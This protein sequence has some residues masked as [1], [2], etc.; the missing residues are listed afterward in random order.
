MLPNAT[1]RRNLIVATIMLGVMLVI[2]GPLTVRADEMTMSPHRIILNAQG[3][4]ENVQAVIRIPLKSGYVL[5][6]YDVTL[7][8]DGIAI[9][10]AYEFRYCYIDDNFLASFERTPIQVNPVVIAMAGETVCATVEGWFSATSA[11]GT[12]YTQT[13]SCNDLVDIVDPDKRGE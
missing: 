13:F 6:D 2:A 1:I 9:S 7:S 3:Q 4:F 12:S 8:F 5:A 10:D 11:D